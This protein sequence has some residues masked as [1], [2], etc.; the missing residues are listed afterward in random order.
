LFSNGGQLFIQQGD[1][2]QFA[3]GSIPN[4]SIWGPDGQ[5]TITSRDFNQSPPA[6]SATL[7]S[8]TLSDNAAT[9]VD[10]V[11]IGKDITANDSAQFNLSMGYTMHVGVPDDVGTL[12]S[13]DPRFTPPA[14][15]WV[16]PTISRIGNTVSII[17][18]IGPNPINWFAVTQLAIVMAP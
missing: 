17:S 3:V 16:P 11:I 2:V 4:P 6:L 1:G 9:K 18:G 7:H 8:F 15:V 14:G 13:S 12:T 10:V 5:Q